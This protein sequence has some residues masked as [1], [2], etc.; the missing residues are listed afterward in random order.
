MVSC[1]RQTLLLRSCFAIHHPFSTDIDHQIALNLKRKFEQEDLALLRKSE[2]ERYTWSEQSLFQ[3]TTILQQEIS[4]FV[5]GIKKGMRNTDI[6]HGI[7]CPIGAD[8]CSL[9]SQF[10]KRADVSEDYIKLVYVFTNKEAS[11]SI[12]KRGFAGS[13]KFSENTEVALSQRDSFAWKFRNTT[14]YSPSTLTTIHEADNNFVTTKIGF[15]AAVV[16]W[17][18]APC[19]SYKAPSGNAT[20]THME[21]SGNILPLVCFD[22][23]MRKN[24]IIRRLVNGFSRILNDFFHSLPVDF[25]LDPSS[26]TKKIKEDNAENR[27]QSPDYLTDF[28]FETYSESCAGFS[29]GVEAFSSPTKRSE[30]DLCK[31]TTRQPANILTDEYGVPVRKLDSMGRWD[32]VGEIL[33][34][35]RV[36]AGMDKSAAASDELSVSSSTIGAFNSLC[37]GTTSLVAGTSA[38]GASGLTEDA[39]I[40]PPCFASRRGSATLDTKTEPGNDD[41]Y[42]QPDFWNKVA[43]GE[44]EDSKPAAVE[45]VQAKPDAADFQSIAAISPETHH[46]KSYD[47]KDVVFIDG[48][49]FGDHHGSTQYELILNEHA[50]RYGV[51]T[52]TSK[53]NEIVSLI[54][55]LI[56]QDGKAVVNANE[57]GWKPMTDLELRLQVGKDLSAMCHTA[58]SFEFEHD[59]SC[60]DAMLHAPPNSCNDWDAKSM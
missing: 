16:D 20:L 7:A 22:A 28:G 54:V 29:V 8:L 41:F 45:C 50:T 38:N 46:F 32:C 42:L 48:F 3:R 55:R 24:D 10:I 5:N 2:A 17:D 59:E 35:E 53:R 34:R 40:L 44:L 49:V 57:G 9:V 39:L 43:S 15:L 27:N 4:T 23:S 47:E 30:S 19:R 36:K 13:V 11:G 37:L 6:M 21:G 26:A 51:L 33:Y 58:R 56:R 18:G 14:N 60:V 31:L 25:G 52:D 1:T 12:L